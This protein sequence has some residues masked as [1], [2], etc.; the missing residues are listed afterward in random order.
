MR[1]NIR[2][3]KKVLS[4]KN[5]TS[6]DFRVYSYLLMLEKH[7]IIDVEEMSNLMKLSIKKIK[8]SIERLA[9]LGYTADLECTA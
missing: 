3:N 5:L 6:E 9:E 1:K 7:E 4:D 8:K 2:I